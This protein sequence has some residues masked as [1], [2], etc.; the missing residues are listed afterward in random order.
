MTATIINPRHIRPAPE[1]HKQKWSP[2]HDDEREQTKIL[3]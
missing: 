3:A 2:S 1:N